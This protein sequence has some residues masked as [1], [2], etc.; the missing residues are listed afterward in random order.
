MAATHVVL[1][2]PNFSDAD[3]AAALAEAARQGMGVHIHG[4]DPSRLPAL[5]DSTDRPTHRALRAPAPPTGTIVLIPARYEFAAGALRRLLTHRPTASILRVYVPGADPTRAVTRFAPEVLTRVG[6]KIEDLPD[7][8]TDPR[9][10]GGGYRLWVRGD[11][12]GIYNRRPGGWLATGVSLVVQDLWRAGVRAPAGR[13]RRAL[14][15]RA[16]R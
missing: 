10:E 9:G 14:R 2:A 3:L 1:P 15:Q 8:R 4:L 16:G 13:A 11:E 6:G 5:R 12:L 7:Y